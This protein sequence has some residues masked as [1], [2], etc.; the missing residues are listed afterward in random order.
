MAQGQAA[1]GCAQQEQ[2]GLLEGARASRSRPAPLGV[3]ILR[4]AAASRF[5]SSEGVVR[6]GG[7]GGRRNPAAFGGVEVAARCSGS[8]V[9]VAAL[10]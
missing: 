3:S 5:V 1:S 8:A 2:A 10:H 4:R 9:A 6:R 7:V